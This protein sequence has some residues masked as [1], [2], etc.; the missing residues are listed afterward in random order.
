MPEPGHLIHV[1]FPKAGSTSLQAWFERH[2]EL[3]Y[4]HGRFGGYRTL[5]HLPARTGDPSRGPAWHVSSEER[6]VLPAPDDLA[7]LNTLGD[8]RERRARA[9]VVLRLL[10]PGA[11]I[12]LV[13]RGFRGALQSIY[14]H[15]VSAGGRLG[16]GEAF[17]S[18]RVD[19]D[20]LLDY[21]EAIALYEQA[22]GAENVIVLPFELLRDDPSAFLSALSKRLGLTTP[23]DEIEH[24]NPSLSPAELYWY[25][26]I[27]RS[28]ER[29]VGRRRELLRLYRARIGGPGLGRIVRVLSTI[30]PPSTWTPADELPDSIV[31]RQRGHAT[32]LATRPHYAP[33]HHDYLND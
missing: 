6:L 27:S 23:V 11:T 10:S 20:A 28:I 3:V 7:D 32:A 4:A 24:L 1:G 12:L 5:R 17:G 33:Y 14:A 31:E 13:T 29:L 26:R 8:V 19:L 2:P 18:S 21:D 16:I 9:C 22:F 30:A 15:F 25:P